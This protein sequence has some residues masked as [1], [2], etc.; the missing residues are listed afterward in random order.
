MN[1]FYHLSIVFPAKSV[2][3]LQTPGKIL[4]FNNENTVY[5]TM[6]SKERILA[7]ALRSI[8]RRACCTVDDK[9]FVSISLEVLENQYTHQS[10]THWFQQ[11][12][13]CCW[14]WF[15]VFSLH[16]EQEGKCCVCV[17]ACMCTCEA[18]MCSELE[19]N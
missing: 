19:T 3:L 10:C 15:L 1:I 16:P 7:T 18:E 2:I 13:P 14:F 6:L 12:Q 4:N 11:A 9:M 5:S 17:G 8:L